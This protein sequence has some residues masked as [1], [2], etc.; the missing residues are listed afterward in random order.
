MLISERA[1]LLKGISHI[2][3]HLAS[4]KKLADKLIS[5]ADS[6]IETIVLLEYVPFKIQSIPNGTCEF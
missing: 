3:P 4:A 2:K 1:R 6:E 5:L